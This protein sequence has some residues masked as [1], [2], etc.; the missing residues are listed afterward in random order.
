MTSNPLS[1]VALAVLFLAGMMPLAVRADYLANT[2]LS[3][4]FACWHGQG[5]PA[6]LNPDGTEGAEGDKGVVPVIRIALSKNSGRAVYQEIDTKDE[7]K[8]LHVRVEVYA[9]SDFK[10]ST[11]A[12]DYSSDINWKSTGTYSGADV[13]PNA[14]FWIH[15]MPST[16]YQLAD[17][18]PGQWVTVE[19]SFDASTPVDERTI[20]FGVPPGTGTVYIRNAS[21]TQ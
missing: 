12:D 21:V 10:R 16:V 6:F 20:Y 9:S 14:D 11:F 17:L 2:D 8:G 3:A 7:P 15:D 5:E 18:K 4:G 19:F 1:P 13:T